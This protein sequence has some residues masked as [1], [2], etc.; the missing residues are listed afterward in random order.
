[1][2]RKFLHHFFQT[3]GKS[4]FP[5]PAAVNGGI[6][7]AAFAH[8]SPLPATSTRRPMAGKLRQPALPTC[9]AAHYETAACVVSISVSHSSSCTAFIIH[10]NCVEQ[11]NIWPTIC[12]LFLVVSYQFPVSKRKTED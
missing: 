8:F 10:E 2:G 9:P 1:M 5:F 4:F 11:E 7:R 3:G 6:T 12:S